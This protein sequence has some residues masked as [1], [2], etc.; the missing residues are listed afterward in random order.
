MTETANLN[1]FNII[2][3]LLIIIILKLKFLRKSVKRAQ[4]ATKMAHFTEKKLSQ[5]FNIKINKNI[6]IYLTYKLFNR[7]WMKKEAK[8]GEKGGRLLNIY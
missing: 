6:I 8:L 7:S 4:K 2:L 5:I 3:L 1:I